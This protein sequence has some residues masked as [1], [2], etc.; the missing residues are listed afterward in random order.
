MLFERDY[1]T[2]ISFDTLKMNRCGIIMTNNVMLNTVDH[3]ISHRRRETGVF[4]RRREAVPAI[5]QFR[6][7][8]DGEWR[9]RWTGDRESSL[10]AAFAFSLWRRPLWRRPLILASADI[11][12]IIRHRMSKVA[13]AGISGALFLLAAYEIPRWQANAL[14]LVSSLPANSLR[15]RQ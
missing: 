10:T 6:R 5:E 11:W 3:E 4:G 8:H 7:P 14:P 9:V 15:G 2:V 13:L 1:F 12:S